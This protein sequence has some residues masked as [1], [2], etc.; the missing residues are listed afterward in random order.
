[1]GKYFIAYK[2]SAGLLVLIY[3]LYVMRAHLR[4]FAGPASRRQE[5]VVPAKRMMEH[6]QA[7]SRRSLRR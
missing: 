1:M 3:L 6:A 2:R 4:N 7:S 5:D